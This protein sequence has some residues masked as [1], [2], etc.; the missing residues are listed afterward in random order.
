MLP[1]LEKPLWPKVLLGLKYGHEGNLKRHLDSELLIGAESDTGVVC[2][3]AR[4]ILI[5]ETL[6]TDLSS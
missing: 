1:N 3:W 4:R 6:S 2:G 5:S